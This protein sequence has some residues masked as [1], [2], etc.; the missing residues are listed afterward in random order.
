MLRAWASISATACSA[1]DKIFDSGALTTI[2]PRL[3]AA[4]TSTLSRPTPAR[5]TA[6]RSL[7]ASSTSAL[8]RVAERMTRAAA[9]ATALRSCSGERESWTSTSVP[10]AAIISRPCGDSR[11]VTRILPIICSSPFLGYLVAELCEE[12]AYSLNSPDKVRVRQSVGEPAVTGCTEGL[13]RDEG[14]FRLFEDEV[15]ELEGGRRSLSPKLPA[16]NA[17]EGGESIEGTLGLQASHALYVRQHLEYRPAAPVEGVRH[18]LNCGEVSHEGRDRGALR[19]VVDVRGLVRLQVRGGFQH[20]RGTDQPPDAP[21]RHGVGLGDA[22]RDDAAV[23]ELRH[24]DRD[25]V[26][27]VALVYEMFVDLVGE[28]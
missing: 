18:L 25:R 2:T 15:R 16:E 22:V 7:P 4:S 28:H 3:V 1:A 9:P 6:T 21:T 23:G 26:L 5:P 24:D 14:D 11:S 17:F 10:A 20:V 12:L 13:S 27:A 19:D 8:T